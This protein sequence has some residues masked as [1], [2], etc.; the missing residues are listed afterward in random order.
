VKI[1]SKRKSDPALVWRQLLAPPKKTKGNLYT[2]LLTQFVDAIDGNQIPEGVR[3]PS[4]RSLA[5]TLKIGRN[6][7]IAAINALIEQGYLVTKDRSGIFVAT[8]RP[9]LA[10]RPAAAKHSTFD[11]RPRLATPNFDHDQR[12]AATASEVPVTHS[13][14][15]G[16]FDPNL[17]PAN[18][19][20]QCERSASGLTEI[21]EWACDVFDRDDIDLVNSLRKHVL[22]S[23]G[24]WA[25]PDEIL[26]TLGGQE[27]RYLVAQLLAKLGVTVGIENP[28]MEDIN[29]IIKNTPAKRVYLPVDRN[30]VCLSSELNQC[31]VIF[32]TPGH[33]F[34]TTAVMT[35]E[36]RT[37]ILE[38]AIRRD[39][40]LVEDTFETELI[41]HGKVVGTLK[42]LDSEGRVIHVGSLSKVIAPGLRIGF[43]VASPFVIRELRA[44]RRL[45]HRHPPGNNQ[46]ALAMF[47]ER[48]FYHSYLRRISSAIAGRTR[49]LENSFR[50]WL[51]EAKL[52]HHEGASSYWVEMPNGIDTRKLSAV[53]RRHGILVEPGDKFFFQDSRSNYLWISVS[54]VPEE[55][56]DIGIQRIADAARF[57]G[58]QM[59]SAPKRELS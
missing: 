45:I 23:H 13:F 41:S 46:R 44:I 12:V 8:R 30:G 47:I 31:D 42:N 29:E 54:Q 15:Y 49:T 22:P 1:A 51:P 56:I 38:A 27:G 26:V 32:V 3:I 7:V 20:R 37:S 53:L 48:G 58:T 9:I 28:G 39:S 52:F 59:H 14:I 35:H 5:E 10:P 50:R 55:K 25:E 6:T 43:V 19:W 40:I 34:P 16:Q 18:H 24:I 21:A 17:F 2:Q 33:H 4:S 11:W 57:L 36:R